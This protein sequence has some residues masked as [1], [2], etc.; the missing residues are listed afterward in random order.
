ML[1]HRSTVPSLLKRATAAW[2]RGPWAWLWA[3]QV[4][5]TKR[6]ESAG[7]VAASA[8]S[9]FC[10]SRFFERKAEDTGPRV[11]PS[12]FAPKT[13]LSAALGISRSPLG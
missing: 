1:A 2:G 3:R 6:G 4:F 10:A 5:R 8:S 13:G 11:L 9:F 12:H 7:S